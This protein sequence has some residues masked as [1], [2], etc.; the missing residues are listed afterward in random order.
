MKILL[1]CGSFRED[2][3][4]QTL[5]TEIKQRL[6][7]H[8]CV[9]FAIQTLPFYDASID[10]EHRNT[11]TLNFLQAVNQANAMIIVSPEYN[12]S[13]P[14]VLKNALDWASRPAMNSA[15]K[16]MPVT[17][18]SAS[19]SPLGGALFQSHIKDV[20]DS[21]LSII[22]P[23]VNYCLGEA[24]K[25]ISHGKLIEETA[26]DRLNRHINSFISWAEQ[27]QRSPH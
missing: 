4:N 18:L 23:H 20:L 12:R 21:T 24:N 10:G 16:D 22:F 19:P 27:H 14:A 5:I 26:I 9:E 11:D 2:S 6:T 3:I 8:T 7:H 17:I 25:K 15:L 1:L 13:I